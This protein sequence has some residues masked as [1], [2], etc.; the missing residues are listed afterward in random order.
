[1]LCKTYSKDNG[2]CASCYSGYFLFNYKC[3]SS[4]DLYIPFCKI[5]GQ[6]GKCAECQDRYYLSND[7]CLPVSLLCDTF[8]KLTGKCL[9][10]TPGYFFQNDEC[11]YPALGIDPACTFYTNSYC[12][13]CK[14]GYFLQN[15]F[16]TQIDSKCLDFDYSKNTCKKCYN[17]NPQGPYCVWKEY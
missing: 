6:N 4:Q 14:P 16:C 7:A 9:T 11:I 10:C 3:V 2:Y 8:N 12:S 5:V 17:S 1:M 15:Y 13:Q